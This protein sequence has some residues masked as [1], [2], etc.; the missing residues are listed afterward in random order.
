MQM[1]RRVVVALALPL[2]LA[3]QQPAAAPARHVAV[4]AA[5]LVDP[6]DGKRIDDVVVLIEGDRV[7]QVGS[8]LAIP[9]GTETIDLGQATLLPGLIDVHTHLTSESG[10]YY[11]DT[12]RRSP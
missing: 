7:T 9:A 2:A 11:D 3:A 8:R 12:F 6:A 4:R 1:L 5:H 10:N